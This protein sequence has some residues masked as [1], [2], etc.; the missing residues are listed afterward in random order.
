MIAVWG[1]PRVR[2]LGGMSR[3]FR[4]SLAPLALLVSGCIA[5]SHPA[6]VTPGWSSSTLAVYDDH[7]IDGPGHEGRVEHNARVQFTAGYGESL[8]VGDS[9]LYVGLVAG[10]YMTSSVPLPYLAVD[11]Y[12]QLLAQ[13]KLGV[14]AGVGFVIGAYPTLYG[15]VGRE[16][17][18]GWRVD[19]GFIASFG[20]DSLTDE[21]GQDQGRLRELA[22]QLLVSG[23]LG[24]LTLSLYAEVP[25]ERQMKWN[26]LELKGNSTDDE[27]TRI[28]G[29]FS[30]GVQ[31]GWAY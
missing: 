16:L 28:T 7:E 4:S 29:G 24:R 18:S 2:H 8:L 26:L 30:A 12:L 17:W 22:P 21:G 5:V 31:V 3:P 14:D 13:H 15:L 1:V 19:A 27:Y 20:F 6:K 25:I 23:D 11:F 9:M 10:G